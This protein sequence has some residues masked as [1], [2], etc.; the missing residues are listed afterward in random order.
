MM[1]H[2]RPGLVL[3]LFLLRLMR[4]SAART[5]WQLGHHSTRK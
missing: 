3:V 5:P 4:L 2:L 1:R